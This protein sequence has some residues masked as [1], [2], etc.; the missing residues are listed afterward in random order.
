MI[1]MSAMRK[2]R[3]FAILAILVF[4]GLTA[5]T[6]E[7]VRLYDR[8][9]ETESSLE[10]LAGEVSSHEI[11]I[12]NLHSNIDDLQSELDSCRSDIDYLQSER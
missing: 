9:S 3:S 10:D 7:V 12:E 6:Y 4:V 11:E 2:P 8:M 1:L 5:V